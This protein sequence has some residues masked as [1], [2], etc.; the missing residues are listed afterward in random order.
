MRIPARS[1][2]RAQT[3]MRLL[4]AALCALLFSCGAPAG[5][6]DSSSD[7]RAGGQQQ[8]TVVVHYPT[9]WGH[10][11]SLRGTGPFTW[12]RG[13]DAS[14][15]QN[16][17]WR[18]TV[19]LQAP[20]QLKPLF[21]DSTWAIGPNWTLAPGQT[22][23]VWPHF[24]HGAGSLEVAGHWWS[25]R[26]QNA[27]SIRV[28]LPPSYFENAG[29]RFPVV[30][31][32]DGQNLFDDAAAFGGVSWNVAFAMDQ[33]ARDG[34]IHEAIVVGVDATMGRIPEYTPVPDPQDGGGNADAYLAFLTDE[35]KP[36]V[37]ATYRTLPGRDSTAIVGSSLGGLVSAYAGLARH[38]VF[39]LLGVMSPSTWWDNDW[40]IGQVQSTKGAVE[41]PIK[42]YVDSGDSGPSND[43]VTQTAR[44]A[45][46]YRDI[47]WVQVD[48][49][50]QKGGQHNETYWRQRVPGALSFLLGPR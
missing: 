18:L 19:G 17:E 49:L 39:G 47:G 21:D 11:I 48:Y 3:M 10:R 24:F 50:V 16:D 9:G 13:L 42:A 46:A 27:R 1:R 32:Q 14:W 22:L 8:A 31:M 26:L 25:N 5:L 40:I 23:D 20:V 34:S 45:Q 4:A 35:L 28:Y 44:L 43:D 30:Y 38:D 7:V 12:S 2:Y 33:G 41:K 29:E 37:D 15:T 6:G 36:W